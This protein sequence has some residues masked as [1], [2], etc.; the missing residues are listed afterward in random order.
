MIKATQYANNWIDLPSI[1]RGTS[2]RHLSPPS[3]PGG[4]QMASPSPSAGPKDFG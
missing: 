4:L 1:S 3:G 2:F